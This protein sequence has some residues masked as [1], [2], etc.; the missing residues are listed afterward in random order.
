MSHRKIPTA[1]LSR[2]TK[3]AVTT[4]HIGLKHAAHVSKKPFSTKQQNAQR[5]AMHEQD[6]GKILIN[7]LMQLRGTALKIAQMMSME[8]D[9]LPDSIRIEL[10][11]ACSEVTPLNRAHI[12][13]VFIEEFKQAPE[14][15]FKQFNANAFAAASLGQVHQAQIETKTKLAI[16]IQY[17]G[18]A[19]SIQSDMKLVRGI[20]KSLSFS[21]SFLPRYDII[22]A[23][24]DKIHE[25]LEREIDYQLEA[26]NTRWFAQHLTIPNVHVPNV[27]PEYSSTKVLAM[28]YLEGDH[29]TQWLKKNPDQQ[30]RNKMGQ[31]LFDLFCFQLHEL[32]TLHADPH[33]GNFIFCENNT[34]ALIDF[35]CI[36]K[37]HPDFP[38]NVIRL[39]SR[40]ADQLYQIY[41]DLGI[42]S[43]SLTL[44][45][46][47]QEFF[48]V[49]EEMY[50]W[51]TA[52]F[53]E[54][55]YD[56]S[57]IQPLPKKPLSQMKNVMKHINDMQQDQM[58]FDRSYF[59]LLN[60]LRKMQAKI[61][62]SGLLLK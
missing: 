32:K 17:P 38:A 25:Q 30:Q 19:A 18:I 21:T 35:G 23:V 47:Q 48:P 10:A 39:F 43:S 2:A 56:F 33:P 1:K 45:Q 26:D 36:H 37:L 34:I 16:K 54:E 62:T 5:K 41:R 24:L 28:Q 44:E 13:K 6:V 50:V 60:M 58:Y 11:K 40:D 9:M 3:T 27:Y 4:A 8:L 12:R 55:V 7:T 15:K 57:K 22:D 29:L 59:G 31:L 14:K 61:N 53:Q 52:P 49:I 42:I 20:M 46:Y 51:M